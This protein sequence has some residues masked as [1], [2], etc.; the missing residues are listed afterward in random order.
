MDIV[1][2]AKA[3]VRDFTISDEVPARV[4]S[5]VIIGG[6]PV[7]TASSITEHTENNNILTA[8]TWLGGNN[9]RS[10][11]IVDFSKKACLITT[12]KFGKNHL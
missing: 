9:G 4:V 1:G 6:L 10:I 8:P 3:L 11:L 2:K 12:K 5:I 7:D